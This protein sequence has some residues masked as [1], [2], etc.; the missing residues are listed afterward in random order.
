MYKQSVN[1][2]DRFNMVDII[3]GKAIL[4]LSKPDA[5]GNVGYSLTFD[6]KYQNDKPDETIEYSN[7]EFSGPGSWDDYSEGGS[8]PYS[9][10]Y[11]AALKS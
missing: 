7:I 9:D 3:T 5:S 1:K 6:Y 8:Y 4:S 10:M 2:G 11:I